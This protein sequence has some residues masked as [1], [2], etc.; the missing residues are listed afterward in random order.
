MYFIKAHREMLLVRVLRGCQRGLRGQRGQTEAKPI[1][2]P[3][4]KKDE[5]LIT[6]HDSGYIPSDTPASCFL[7]LVLGKSL[8]SFQLS[9]YVNVGRIGKRIWLLYLF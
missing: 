6:E 5:H 3:L 9:I 1:L 4:I 8:K 2:F 7:F